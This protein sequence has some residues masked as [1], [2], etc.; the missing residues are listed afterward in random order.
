MTSQ[1]SPIDLQDL[2]ARDVYFLLTSVVVPRPIAWVST[3]DG[4]GRSNLAPFSYFNGVC[5][6]PPLISIS[7]GDHKGQP[8]D[9]FR[10]IQETGVFCVNL[11]EDKHLEAM[12]QSSGAYPPE[13]S[14]FDV[15][16]LAHAPCDSIPCVRVA[17]AR[18]A[19]E[20]KLVDVHTYGNRNQSHLVVGEILK[21]H[22]D[23]SLRMAERLV[24][25]PRKMK[26]V[27]RLG[28]GYYAFLE[29]PIAR[30]PVKLPR[31]ETTS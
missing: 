22:L 25:D 20:C 6:D 12:H 27:G 13:I 19:L 11:V 8:K 1:T 7:I 26:P 3:V 17:D 14:E 9:S 21:V 4:D 24:A 10:A 29:P 18:T 28:A 2:S 15:T 31:K 30:P 16:D 23:D 5:S